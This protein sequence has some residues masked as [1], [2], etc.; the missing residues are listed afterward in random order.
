MLNFLP[1]IVKYYTQLNKQF[2]VFNLETSNDHE[3]NYNPIID[4]ATI[5]YH[6]NIPVIHE[7]SKINFEDHIS[8][9]PSLPNYTHAVPT[10][11]IKPKKTS[12]VVNPEVLKLTYNIINR[13][14]LEIDPKHLY[15]F[16]STTPSNDYL[17]TLYNIF[18]GVS[19]L[20]INNRLETYSNVYTPI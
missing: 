5:T 19:D 1:G 13:F 6:K 9:E 4:N 7:Q 3:K 18:T 15:G 14:D 20:P 2:H 8:L 12:N 16:L 11:Q 10:H 17:E